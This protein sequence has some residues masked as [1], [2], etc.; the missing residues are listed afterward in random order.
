M[1]GRQHRGR[2]IHA[3]DGVS[4]DVE[5]G[6]ILGLLGRNGAGK[7]TMLRLLGNVL[8]PTFGTI[9]IDRDVGGIFELGTGTS[10]LMTGDQFVRRALELAGVRGADAGAFLADAREFS[11]L[12]EYFDKPIGT[13]SSGMAARLY[14]A[15]ATAPHHAIYLIDEALSVGDE[16]FQAKCWR[17]IRERLGRG[18]SGVFVTHDWPSVLRLC[19][20]AAVMERGRIAFI[21][22]AQ[23]AVRRYV[24][25][26]D[27]RAFDGVRFDDDLALEHHARSGEDAVLEFPVHV[28]RP[29]HLEVNF[30][31][32]ALLPALG[33]EILLMGDRPMRIERTGRSRVC[34]R[35]P[36]L[37]VGPGR[38]F[39]HV[40]LVELEDPK[41]NP[42]RRPQD[43]RGWTRGNSLHLR[44]D[45]A[46][47]GGWF[48]VPVSWSRRA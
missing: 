1:T 2:E 46:G 29:I 26:P 34:I 12:G 11:E 8:R 41:G 31:I 15:A 24:A 36:R 6:E 4:F 42:T 17:R 9:E 44:V 13:Y 14:F 30:V 37:P 5:K 23:E 20:R 25:I 32:E 16:H 48:D 45:G 7:S 21:G 47:A 27:D 28:L 35:I 33:W 10:P 22:T 39:L 40:G 19:R 3:V 38:Y 18:A 43:A